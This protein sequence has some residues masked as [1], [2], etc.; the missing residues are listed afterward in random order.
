MNEIPGHLAKN[1][2]LSVHPGASPGSH[3][4]SSLAAPTVFKTMA[5]FAHKG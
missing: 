4:V 2:N 1:F 3:L 5:I